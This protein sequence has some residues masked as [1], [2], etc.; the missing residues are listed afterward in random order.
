MYRA[1]T[2]LVLAVLVQAAALRADDTPAPSRRGDKYYVAAAKTYNIHAN[3]HVRIL[4]KYA[5]AN[6]GKVSGEVIKEH[7]AEMRRNLESAKKAYAKISPQ[8]KKN[9]NIA[10][11]LTEVEQRLDKAT[12]LIDQLEAASAK[13]NAEAKQV[14]AQTAALSRELQ[15]THKANKAIDQA[16]AQSLHSDDEF[17]DRQ[18]DSY[19]FTGEGHFID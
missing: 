4:N 3:D 6:G 9:P 11:Q 8:G 13:D 17:E 16:V 12:A 1:V 18:S 7:T 14:M 2:T 15:A 10:A 19:Y 5:A